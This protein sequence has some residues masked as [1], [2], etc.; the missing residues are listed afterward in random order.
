[1]KRILDAK[2]IWHSFSLVA[3]AYLIATPLCAQSY[4]ILYAPQ[5]SNSETWVCADQNNNPI[6][7]AAFTVTNGVYLYTNSHEHDDISHPFS[8]ASPSS[9][10]ADGSGNFTF[11]VNTTLVGQAESE[12]LQCSNGNGTAYGA[13]DFGVGYSD[14]YWDDHPEEY[15]QIG[16]STTGHGDNTGNHWMQTTPAY[17]YYYAVGSY[18]ANYN[19]GN[20]VC[21]NDMALPYGGKFDIQDNWTSPHLSHDR[22]S[23]VDTATSAGQCPSANVV[24]NTSAFLLACVQNGAQSYPTS[25]VDPYDVHCN[26]TNPSAYPH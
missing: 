5:S 16:G 23:A 8:S 1:M 19:S 11:S 15:I 3:A 26:W 20:P 7:Y 9:G 22:G 4:A 6:P 18:I 10:Y 12:H 17:G 13:E 2:D 25:Q 21:A 24:T 14:I